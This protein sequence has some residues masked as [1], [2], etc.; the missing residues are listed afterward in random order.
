ME[1]V[2]GRKTARVDTRTEEMFRVPS[3]TEIWEV[4]CSGE[5]ES[6]EREVQTARKRPNFPIAS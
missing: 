4:T 5:R 1:L 3:A 6:D 2:K